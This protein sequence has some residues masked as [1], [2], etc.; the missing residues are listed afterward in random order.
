MKAAR[1]V[2]FVDEPSCMAA[3]VAQVVGGEAIAH[4]VMRGPGT[5]Q[6]GECHAINSVVQS[7]KEAD[8][9]PPDLENS[10][11]TIGDSQSAESAPKTYVANPTAHRMITGITSQAHDAQP[12]ELNIPLNIAV[13]P[14][15]RFTCVNRVADKT[16]LLETKALGHCLL[17]RPF[18]FAPPEAQGDQYQLGPKALGQYLHRR[19]TA[20][21]VAWQKRNFGPNRTAWR[22]GRESRSSGLLRR[23]SATYSSS[24]SEG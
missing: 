21:H 5:A 14:S 20:D 15:H 17:R 3:A 10:L 9:P 7:A 2:E 19:D 4:T 11:W 18:H 6:E 16:V 12:I 24:G 8:L 22:Q 1:R 13:T 23:S